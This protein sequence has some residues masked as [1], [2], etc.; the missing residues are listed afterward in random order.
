[1]TFTPDKPEL[2]V[3]LA[4]WC[5]PDTSQ[6]YMLFY[7]CDEGTFYRHEE[8]W[9]KKNREDNWDFDLDGLITIYVG[10][11]FIPVYDKAEADNAVLP[12]EEV[13]KYESISLLETE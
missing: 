3:D 2:P 4:C 9:I 6:S 12:I 5:D 10:P 8:K 13:V 11:A 7:N 1:M